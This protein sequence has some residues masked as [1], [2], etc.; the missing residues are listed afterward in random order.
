MTGAGGVDPTGRHM[1]DRVVVAEVRVTRSGK[2]APYDGRER[3][4]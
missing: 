1:P 2:V 4:R 3:R